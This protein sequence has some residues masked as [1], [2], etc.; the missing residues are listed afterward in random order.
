MSSL[1]FVTTCCCELLPLPLATASFHEM[2]PVAIYCWLW[3]L[4]MQSPFLPLSLASVMT[5]GTRLLPLLHC[6]CLLCHCSGLVA[7]AIDHYTLPLNITHCLCPCDLISH[8]LQACFTKLDFLCLLIHAWQ[9]SE[10]ICKS[11]SAKS[12]H[13][14]EAISAEAMKR[15]AKPGAFRDNLI[16]ESGIEPPVDV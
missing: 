9:P 2:L 10:A 8:G 16:A 15:A 4:H 7:I 13:N 12:I 1:L 6:Q 3:S 5:I 14:M 11:L